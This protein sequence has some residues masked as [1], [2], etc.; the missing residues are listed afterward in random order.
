MEL[1]STD[2]CRRRQSLVRLLNTGKPEPLNSFAVFFQDAQIA[3]LKPA[4]PAGV[5]IFRIPWSYRHEVLGFGIVIVVPIP[6]ATVAA[7]FQDVW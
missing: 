4:G 6:Q 7:I 2:D 3:P 5:I 1:G